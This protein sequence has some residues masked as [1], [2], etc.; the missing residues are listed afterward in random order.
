ML[1]STESKDIFCGLQDLAVLWYTS[2]WQRST[3]S[4]KFLLKTFH[5]QDGEKL[6]I[7]V[8]G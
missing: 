5:S 8:F 4:Q 7:D 3:D 1:E 6:P 2:P